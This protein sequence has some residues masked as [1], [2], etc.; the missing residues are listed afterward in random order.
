MNLECSLLLAA[1]VLEVLTGPIAQHQG[2]VRSLQVPAP[3]KGFYCLPQV[4]LP[5]DSR[6]RAAGKGDM[7]TLGT[8]TSQPQPAPL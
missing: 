7:G 8:L 4:M 1:P 6:E 3:A 5:P 2:P